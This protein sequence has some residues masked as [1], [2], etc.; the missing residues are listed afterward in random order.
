M[1]WMPAT[2][3][4]LKLLARQAAVEAFGK[5]ASNYQVGVARKEIEKLL[6]SD[7]GNE[8]LE[9]HHNYV[10]CKDE[11]I[12]SHIAGILNPVL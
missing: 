12:I 2:K 6:L 11:L 10:T 3:T 9:I 5:S 7:N 4:K 8:Y 1:I